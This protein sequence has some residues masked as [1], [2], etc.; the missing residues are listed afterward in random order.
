MNIGTVLDYLKRYADSRFSNDPFN[1]VDALVLSMLSY[2]SFENIVPGVNEKG[3]ITLEEATRHYFSEHPS[4]KDDPENIG[5]T[6]SPSMDQELIQMLKM[7]SKSARYAEIQLSNFVEKTDFPAEQQFAAITYSLPNAKPNKVIAFRG[8]DRTLIGWK[9]NFELAYMKKVPAQESA[10]AYLDREIRIL[11]GKV[12]VCGH[13]KGGNLA[14]YAASRLKGIKRSRLSRIVNFD[15]PGFNFS[16][17]PRSSFSNCASKVVNYVPEESIVGVLLDTVGERNVITSSAHHLFQHNPVTW[18]IERS[19]FLSGELS[20]TTKLFEETVEKWLS[21]LTL[22]RRK[23]FI[24]ALFDV[25]GASEGKAVDAKESLED[26][27]EVIKN[28]SDLDE[29][30]RNMLSEVLASIKDQ[31]FDTISRALREKLSLD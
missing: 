29:E 18:G 21:Q 3:K 28:I 5:I 15:G 13:S 12:T 22:E 25:L 16:I 1:D 10:S 17:L 19:E 14:V 8:T 4:H 27:S 9:E 7:T 2:L 24:D 26:I 6:V 31:A 30:T 23:A 11:S 20:E